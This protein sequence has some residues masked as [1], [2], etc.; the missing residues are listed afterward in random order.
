MLKIGDEGKAVA[1]LVNDLRKL[2]FGLAPT[3]KFDQVVKKSVEAFQVANVDASGQPLIVDG[4][5]GPHTRWAL[6]TA[7]GKHSAVYQHPTLPTFTQSGGSQAGLAALNVAQAEIGRGEEGSDN[8]GPDIKKYFAGHGNEGQSWCAAF[9][10]YCFNQGQ[11]AVFGYQTSAQALHN[12]MKSLGYSYT[13]SLSN[14]PQPG[15]II[16][17]LRVD[18]KKQQET[19]W[20]GH[21]GIVKS[22]ADG[23]LWTI[24]GNRGAYPSK[25]NI[26]HYSWSVLVASA[27]N[28]KF[29][30]LYGLS[31]HP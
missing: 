4:K 15:D 19:A 10:S 6:D 2:L 16:C 3:D 23:I 25:V 14:P 21:V 30:G 7:L 8:H 27:T 5:V 17:W 22:Y 26:F 9:V 29:K 1:Q 11:T 28:D 24:E 12:K 18:P 31:R 20:M 13:P